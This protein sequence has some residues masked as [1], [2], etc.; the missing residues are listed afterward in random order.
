MTIN[1]QNIELYQGDNKNI[2]IT[3]VDDNDAILNLTGYNAVWCMHDQTTREI[4]IQKTTSPAEG[5][6]IPIPTN[7]EIIMELG[8]E[9]TAN[10]IPKTYGYQCEIEDASG[11]HATITTGYVKIFRSITHHSF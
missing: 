1:G 7:G 5:I 11:N 6:T 2:I 3:V 9:D 4:I 8:Q 10:V